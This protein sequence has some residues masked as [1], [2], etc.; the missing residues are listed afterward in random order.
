MTSRQPGAMPP[1]TTG[2]VGAP[3]DVGARAGARQLCLRLLPLML[4]IVLGLAG[5]RGSVVTPR[6]NGALHRDG[7]TVGIAL[8]AVFAILIVITLGRT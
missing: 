2:H 3:G 6:W 8:E 1:E 4:L 5:L 7:L